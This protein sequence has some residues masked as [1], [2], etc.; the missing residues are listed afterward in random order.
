MADESMTSKIAQTDS[1]VQTFRIAMNPKLLEAARSG[2]KNILDELLRP[3]AGAS[4]GETALTV[5]EDATTQEDISCILGVTQEGN[6]VLHIVASRGHLEIAKKI[7]CREIS[8]LGVPN[9]RLD[10]PLHCAARAGDDKMVSLI[11]Q[12]AREGEIEERRVLRVRNRDEANALHEA[13]KYNHASMAKVLMDEDAKL[14]SMLNEAG[15][16]PLY[17]AIATG[18]LDVAKALLKSSSWEKHSRAP[19]VGPNKKTVLHEAVLLSRGKAK[20]SHPAFTEDY[21]V[22]I[23]RDLLD[24]EPTLANVVDSSGRNPLYYVALGGRHDTVKLLLEHDRSTAY[25]PDANGSFPIHKAASMGNVRILNQILKQGP[26]TDELLDE[27]G[28]NFLHVAFKK[29]K[30][31]VV[32]KIISK[33]PDL[34]K[35]LNDQDN[36]G[37]TPLHTAVKNGDQGCVHFLL[38][39]KTVC[40]DVLNHDGFTPLDLAYGMLGEDLQFRTVKLLTISC[41]FCLPYI[42]IHK[43]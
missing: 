1:K 13:A 34:R 9:T 25:Q 14:A 35:L 40:V 11:I 4:V 23:T 2:N 42:T 39:D 16:S 22:E 43:L 21:V 10:T 28:K 18:S 30:F 36:E 31:D 24:R 29:G 12:F 6:T 27:E 19:Y 17:L 41:M 3:R 8:L 26:D 33:R 7:C 32:K 15:M 20:R 38:R 5:R 37:N